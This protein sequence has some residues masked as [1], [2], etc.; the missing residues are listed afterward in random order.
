MVKYTGE[1]SSASA[2]FS[3]YTYYVLVNDDTVTWEQIEHGM[4]SSRFGDW[5][6]HQTVYRELIY[7]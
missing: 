2:V 5:I 6:D 1:P 3:D 4:F 7:K